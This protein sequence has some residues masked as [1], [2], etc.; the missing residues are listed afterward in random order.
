MYLIVGLGNPGEEYSRT[1][2]NMGFDVLDK[3]AQKYKIN[4]NRHKYEGIYGKGEIEGEKVILLKPQTY[5]NLSGNSVGQFVSFFKLKEE[6]I[7]VIYDDIDVATGTIK[8]RKQGSAGS[9]NGMKSVIK[10]LATEKFPRVRVGTG[11]KEGIQHLTDY[12]LEKLDK[13]EYEELEKG[14]ELASEG[15]ITIL[16][17]GIDSAMNKFNA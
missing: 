4:I 16:K 5:M 13:K 8:I 9:H 14:I 1:R 7:I 10:E 12:V 6:E 2:H 3:L 15:I 17:S 11:N